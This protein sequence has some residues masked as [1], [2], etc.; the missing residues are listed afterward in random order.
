MVNSGEET[1]WAPGSY[2]QIIDPDEDEQDVKE[3]AIGKGG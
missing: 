3:S 2:L 1:G